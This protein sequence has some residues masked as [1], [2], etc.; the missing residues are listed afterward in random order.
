MARQE[1]L[2][3]YAA[4]RAELLLG[5]YRTGD[6]NDP[7]TYV[8]AITAV[9]AHYP[10]E[11]MTS[12]THPVT[13]LPS[14]CGWLPTIKEVTHACN[15]A[16]EPIKQREARQKRIRE[17][18]EMRER[19]EFG[20]KPTMD[21]LKEKYGENWGLTPR[22]PKEAST[23]KAPSWGDITQAY[24]AQPSRLAKLLSANSTDEA[25]A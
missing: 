11:V 2:T 6:A 14:E 19:E 23:F 18:M 20:I 5:C 4:K 8:A 7:K 15:A 22:E 17:Q 10:E 24:A 3:E 21:Q 25:A 9:L 16:V 1:G 12:V 13:G